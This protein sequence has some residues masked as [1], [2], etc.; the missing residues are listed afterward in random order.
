MFV[1]L[2]YSDCAVS[3]RV[4]N[5]VRLRKWNDCLTGRPGKRLH[6][7]QAAKQPDFDVGLPNPLQFNNQS[8]VTMHVMSPTQ[9]PQRV[10]GVC[11]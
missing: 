10:A 3:E 6:F 11:R 9:A 4:A 7:S 2:E 8:S 1:H 5:M